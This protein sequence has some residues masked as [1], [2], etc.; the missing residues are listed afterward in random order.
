MAVAVLLV[1]YP[2]SI[3]PMAFLFQY[4]EW[5]PLTPSVDLM[6]RDIYSPLDNL[7]DPMGTWACEWWNLGSNLG[8]EAYDRRWGI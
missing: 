2:L 7:P 4:V 6:L 1:A 3:G 8:A 5:G